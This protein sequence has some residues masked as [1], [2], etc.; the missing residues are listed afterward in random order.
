MSASTR[1]SAADRSSP[2]ARLHALDA[3]AVL[4]P[5]VA[6][7]SMEVALEAGLP[8]YSGG[9]GVLAGDV[10]RSAADL[11]LP[12]IGFSL[13]HRSGYFVQR[14]D[15]AGNQEELPEAWDP[16][17]RLASLDATAT[18][19]IEGRQ[20]RFRAWRYDIVGMSGAV[21]PVYLLDTALDENDPIDRILTD[22]LYGGDGRYRLAQ[23]AILGFGGYALLEAMGLAEH[24]TTF[25]MNEGHAALLVAAA[26]EARLAAR[27]DASVAS[28][29]LAAVRRRFVFTTHTPVPAGHDRFNLDMVRAV[30]GESRT[31]LVEVLGG[32]RDG[33]MHMT[34]LALRNS[35]FVNA[36]GMRHGEVSRGLFPGDPIHAISNGVHAVRWTAPA[37]ATVFDR[38]VPS[39]RRDNGYLRHAVGIPL[40]DVAAAHRAAKD[41]LA[42]AVRRRTGV[43]LDP[44]RFTIGFARRAATYKRGYLAFWDA[45]RLRA[46]AER[47]GP[48]QFVFAG[49]AHPR[50]ADGKAIIRQ[51]FQA[52]SALG[53]RVSFLYLENHEMA[54]A[55]RLCA[56]VDLW[57]NTPQPPFEASGTSGMKA[58]L[59]GV[60]S[61]STLDG[62]WIEGCVEGR[63]GWAI[64]DGSDAGPQAD[65]D[66]LYDKLEQA[67]VPLF[68]DDPEEYARTMRS[69]IALNGSYFNTQR[70]VEQYARIAYFADRS[71]ARL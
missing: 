41:D 53:D 50:D 66:M 21:V 18:V 32:T 64:G 39:W 13:V 58:A 65:A 37:F 57:L 56:G 54:L 9:L 34:Y 22:E 1:P 67:I 4:R 7:F 38:Y 55:Q 16:R 3:A 12:V 23:E 10:L 42:V 25:H 14:L 29:D 27:G 17:T 30:I 36:V 31:R 19:A 52:A 6:Y 49:K 60:P 2:D 8:T 44:A 68:Y 15:A 70:V 5:R 48:L 47:I 24:I 45:E 43:V 26:L 11:E 61:L 51:I 59:N 71:E 40:D 46:I 20:V 33:A 69:V 35:R 62:W 28:D 63:T